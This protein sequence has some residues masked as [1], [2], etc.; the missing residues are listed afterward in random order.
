MKKITLVLSAVL[1]SG[2]WVS[3]L[4][5]TTPE[6]P[7]F[8]IDTDVE[9]QTL[10]QLDKMDT[11]YKEMK[12]EVANL[13]DIKDADSIKKLLDDSD[14]LIAQSTDLEYKLNHDTTFAKNYQGYLTPDKITGGSGNDYQSF[15]KDNANKTLS[16]INNANTVI[17]NTKGVSDSDVDQAVSTAQSDI[18]NAPGPTQAVAGLSEINT[19]MLRELQAMHKQLAAIAEAQNA[20][21]AKKIEEE[22]T[23]KAEFDSAITSAKA[24]SVADAAK[25][26][27]K[28]H[29]I[30]H[31]SF[32]SSSKK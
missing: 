29:Y 13:K 32:S 1:M 17:D 12:A 4:A 30:E 28:P 6:V 10:T 23:Q 14:S 16:T 15:Y 21:A 26:K 18:K 5:G 9:S 20:D 3:G 25:I 2:A 24:S 22:A 8:V 7:Q 27:E 11:Q 31:V 19:Q